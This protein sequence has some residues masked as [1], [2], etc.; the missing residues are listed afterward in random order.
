MFASLLSKWTTKDYYPR[1]FCAECGGLI[2]DTTC[3]LCNKTYPQVDGI[4]CLLSKGDEASELFQRYLQ[5]YATIAKD[6]IAQDMMPVH[7]KE[8]Q[9]Q[10][11]VSY[12][13]RIGSKKVLDIGAGKGMVLKRIKHDNKVGTDISLEYLRPLQKSGVKVIFNNAERLPFINEF[14]IIFLSDILEHVLDPL[15]VLRNVRRALK[16]RGKAIIRVP[17]K[18]DIAQYS[19]EAGCKYEF[20]H[21]RSFDEGSLAKLIK[22]AGLQ[23]KKLHYD[24]FSV[25]R[26]YQERPGAV[27]T[28]LVEKLSLSRR[29]QLESLEQIETHSRIQRLPWLGSLIFHARV[30]KLALP[31]KIEASRIDPF[32]CKLPNWLAPEFFKPIEITAVVERDKNR[33]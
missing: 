9:A 28:T 10:K 31:N 19:K 3:F 33:L 18:E 7:Y 17:Y 26:I 8:A 20:V 29:Y 16:P 1:L 4:L 30:I 27:T 15:N 12:A 25:N 22:D 24:G 13:G 23:V 11:L 14:D 6:D 32:I 2:K 5:N 21:L